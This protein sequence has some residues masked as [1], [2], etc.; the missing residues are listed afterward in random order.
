MPTCYELW[1]A[2]EDRTIPF[3]R[4]N[5]NGRRLFGLRYWLCEYNGGIAGKSLDDC[6]ATTGWSDTNK[7]ALFPCSDYLI[8]NSDYQEKVKPGNPVY[9][10]KERL[11]FTLDLFTQNELLPVFNDEAI[12]ELYKQIYFEKP[13]LLA[14]LQELQTQIKG[15]QKV[16]LL[17]LILI[18]QHCCPN[19]ISR[20]LMLLSSS[21]IRPCSS[22]AGNSW[23]K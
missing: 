13:E 10:E 9:T 6:G 8:Q 19:M 11:Q 5:S 2:V 22:G 20:L 18:T 3:Y 7:G 21:I 12:T 15:L 16:T 4:D 14:Q 1:Q 23:K 17:H